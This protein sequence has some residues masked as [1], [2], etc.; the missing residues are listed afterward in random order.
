MRLRRALKISLLGGAIALGGL[1]LFVLLWPVPAFRAV[2]ALH[3]LLA[4]NYRAAYSVPAT[5]VEVAVELK[6][7]HPFLAEYERTLILANPVN[8]QEQKMFP[9][10]GGYLRTNLYSLGGGRFLVK[11]FFDEWLVQTQPLQINESSQTTQPGGTFIGAFDDTGDGRWRF[12]PAA[13]RIEQPL[14]ARGG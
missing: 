11:G 10:T 14:V 4:P 7:T 13:E 8:R 3:V 1:A 2:L 5:N 12:I 9:D 6:P